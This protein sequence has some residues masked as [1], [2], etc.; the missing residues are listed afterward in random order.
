L[1]S[2]RDLQGAFA[3]AVRFGDASSIA[4]FVVANGVES[5]R[6]VGIYAKNVRENFLAALEA[7][8]PVLMRLSGRDW[9][10]QTGSAYLRSYPSRSGNLHYVGERFAAF[11]E[12]ELAG[13]PYAYFADVARLEWAYQEVLVAAE[14]PVLDLAA[15]A[16]I[17]AEREVDLV[18][19][20]SPA[21]RLVDSAYPLLA[22]WRA[23]QPGADEGIS[24]RL[25]AGASRL[26]VIRRDSHVELRELPPGEFTFLVAVSRSAGVIDAAAA[27]LATDSEFEL[28]AALPRLARL[29]AL[30]G[31]RLRHPDQTFR[32]VE[33]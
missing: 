27:A 17:P 6:R 11:L 2:L 13:G 28:I 10:R 31:F 4:R 8:F 1:V 3:G 20:A 25:D 9:F 19:E 18:F 33:P 21:A 15:L 32:S 29:G 23:N 16:A 24:V 22:I 12:A 30:T 7:G 26:L 5:E 14:P